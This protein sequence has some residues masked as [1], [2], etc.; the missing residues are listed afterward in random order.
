MF[1]CAASHPSLTA[2]AQDQGIAPINRATHLA[3]TADHVHILDVRRKS[4]ADELVIRLRIDPGYHINA[5]PA[6]LEYLI[7]TALHL[8]DIVPVRITYPAAVHFKPKLADEELDVY[9]G[10]VSI[11]AALPKGTL[12]QSPAISGVLTAQACTEVICLS[13]AD[14]M[15]PP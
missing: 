6:S 11:I 10:T 7:P 5:N 4:E 8:A 13:P 14:L 3:G 1:I 15:L 2:A 9:E 12:S